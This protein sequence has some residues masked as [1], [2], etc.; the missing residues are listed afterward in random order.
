M[1]TGT[2]AARCAGCWRCSS[3][4][5]AAPSS[6]TWATTRPTRTRSRRWPAW[7]PAFGWAC[8]SPARW[9]TTTCATP[10]RWASCCAGCRARS[11]TP[12]R[13][14]AAARRPWRLHDTGPPLA[15]P[16]PWRSQGEAV[17]TQ[18]QPPPSSRSRSASARPV[19][20]AV[21]GAGH[22]SQIAM[23]PAF[24]HA[25]GSE[26]VALVS[27]DPTKRDELQRRHQI[28]RVL[29]YSGYDELLASGDVDA[30]YIALPN[31]QHCDYTVR[32]ARHGV[33][34]LCEKPMAVDESECERMIRATDDA[35]VF[36]MIA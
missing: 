7:A 36:L 16:S 33:H 21:V 24:D 9:P 32:A 25:E 2:R 26:L 8:R 29:P 28:D 17:T 22:I 35:G 31:D 4:T 3:S 20:Y 27:G 13:A 11:T 12:E 10:S 14:R 5:R 34:V 15:E 19:R 23:L 18:P 1:S 6:S 30:V